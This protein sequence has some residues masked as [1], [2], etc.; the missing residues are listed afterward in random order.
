[1]YTVQYVYA[2][3]A[4]FPGIRH[5]SLLFAFNFFADLPI[6][7]IIDKNGRYKWGRPGNEVLCL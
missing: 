6:M 2:W 4:S 1:M 5:F 7:C 3:L